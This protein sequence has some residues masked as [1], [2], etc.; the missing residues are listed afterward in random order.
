MHQFHVQ[1]EWL[2]PCL[3]DNIVVGVVDFCFSN[4]SIKCV[5]DTWR[6]FFSHF[7]HL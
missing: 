5:L 6:S 4:V 3:F 7:H 2:L 1:I